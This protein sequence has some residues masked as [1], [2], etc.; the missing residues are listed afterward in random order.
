MKYSLVTKGIWNVDNISWKYSQ[1]TTYTAFINNIQIQWHCV[2]CTSVQVRSLI[3]FLP[4]SSILLPSTNICCKAVKSLA[5]RFPSYWHYVPISRTCVGFWGAV[6]GRTSFWYCRLPSGSILP[7]SCCYGLDWNSWPT[8]KSS[9]LS[10][11]GNTSI[12]RSKLMK[13]RGK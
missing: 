6:H 9:S 2:P 12:H 5:S 13:C 11:C 7:S 8:L 3:C 10:A 4:L 1:T